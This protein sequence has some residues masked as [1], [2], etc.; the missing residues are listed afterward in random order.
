MEDAVELHIRSRNTELN[1][2]LRDLITRRMRSA[3]ERFEDRIRALRVL[4][5][6]VNGPRGG[7]DKHVR[8]ELQLHNGRSL[9]IEELGA[10]AIAAAATAADRVGQVLGRLMNRRASERRQRQSVRGRGVP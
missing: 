4:I 8:T 6:D 1:D 2:A 3:L 10:D 7:N 9:R 5:S